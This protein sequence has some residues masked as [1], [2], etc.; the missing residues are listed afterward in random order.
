VHLNFPFAFI[1]NLLAFVTNLVVHL[2]PSNTMLV[3]VSSF[4]LLSTFAI[5]F[6]NLR[7]E[8]QEND[9]LK[10]VSAVVQT[11]NVDLF[12]LLNVLYCLPCSFNLF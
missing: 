6:I 2:L 12:R 3:I 8:R 5:L 10:I 7:S 9:A 1:G 11:G 4:E